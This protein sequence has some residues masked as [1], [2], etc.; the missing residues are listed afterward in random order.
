MVP[1]RADMSPE[2]HREFARAAVLETFRWADGHA[3]VWPL[4]ADAEVFRTLTTAMAA[5]WQ[6]Y[7]ITHACGIESRGFLLGGAVRCTSVPASRPCERATDCSRDPRSNRTTAPDYRGLVH[8]L[9]MQ[10]DMLGPDARV[11]LVDDWAERGSQAT[12][13]LELVEACGATFLGLALIVDQLEERD[14]HAAWT[15]GQHRPRR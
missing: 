9:R 3:D 8:R 7:G 13:V 15:C 4:F 10:T 5:A 12:A 1:V 14:A 6:D 2:E 11:L